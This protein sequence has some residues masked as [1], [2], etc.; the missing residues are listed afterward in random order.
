M[1]GVRRIVLFS[2]VALAA[3]GSGAL[4]L[5]ASRSRRPDTRCRLTHAAFCD[6]FDRPAGT[7]GTRSGQL[8]LVWGVSRVS[9]YDNPPQNQYD[10]WAGV[11]LGARDDSTSGS[12]ICGRVHPVFADHDV[13]ICHGQLVE[14]TDDNAYQTVLAMYPRQPFDFAG[15]TGTVVFDVSDDSQGP[16]GAWPAFAITDLPVP[17]PYSHASAIDDDARYS[18]GFAL[19]GVCGQ[20][21]CGASIGVTAH[22]DNYPPGVDINSPSFHCVTVGSVYET[23]DYQVKDIP[24]NVD[25]CVEPSP[26]LGSDNHVEVRINSRGIDVYASDPGRPSTT[27]LIAN[28]GFRPPLTRGLVWIEDVHYNANKF[29]HQQSNSF[30]WDNVGFDG[31]V[32]PRD[33]GFDVPDNHARAGNAYNHVGTAVN[34][35]PTYNL[36]YDIPYHHSLEI[37]V[38]HVIDL[39][40][41]NGALLVF[42]YFPETPQSMTVSVNGH[43]PLHFP[44]PNTGANNAQTAAIAV[45]RSEIHDGTDILSFSDPENTNDGIDIANIDLIAKGAG[46]I[47]SP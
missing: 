16:H 13:R 37:K 10:E 45:P 9:G 17:A 30:S 20:G 23:V 31:P 38:R 12:T 26:R 4:A 6:S 40:D 22:G 24:F 35:L 36:G 5:A 28:A 15:R 39:A 27:R 7:A 18:V 11:Y 3:I 43:A 25:G 2:L 47:V 19:D 21:G 41:A 46:G 14:S 44:W 42:N 32:L 29:D 34:G 8:S 33:L 1:S